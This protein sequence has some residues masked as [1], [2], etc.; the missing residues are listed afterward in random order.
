MIEQKTIVVLGQRRSGTSMISGILYYLGIPVGGGPGQVGEFNE[1]GFFE[2]RDII[3]ISEEILKVKP[4]N[5]QDYTDR[6]KM[7]VDMKAEQGIWAFKDVNQVEL[8][9]L[10][11]PLLPNPYYLFIFRNPV[12]CTQSLL[13]WHDYF[14][15]DQTFKAINQRN[16]RLAQMYETY[17]RNYPCLLISY[18]QYLES[19]VEK[20][21]EII[22]FLG[23]EVSEEEKQRAVNHI[24]PKSKYF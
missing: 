19:P 18:E 8:H 16:L 7:V 10:Y 6:I 22:D 9:P 2:D 5:S 20:V 14:D 1:K 3:K 21:Q 15:F 23:I 24:D 4:E 12:S 13:R 17:N 11:Q